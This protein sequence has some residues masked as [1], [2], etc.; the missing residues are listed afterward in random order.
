MLREAFEKQKQE[1]N[2]L[3][4]SAIEYSILKRDLDSNRTLYEGLLEKLKEA[5]VTAGL[6]SNNFR[7]IDAARVPTAP[8]RTEYS[9]QSFV[10]IGT[11]VSYPA[12]AWPS[13]SKTWTTPFAPPSRHRRSPVFRRLG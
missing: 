7:I 3:N 6:R 2:K 10:R 9:P 11:R 8:E 1:A 5:G 4:E 13:C 12:S